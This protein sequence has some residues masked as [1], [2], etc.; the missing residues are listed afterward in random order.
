ME[1]KGLVYHG[2]NKFFTKFDFSNTPRVNNDYYGGPVY[3]TDTVPIAQTYAQAM[4]RRYGGNK[5]IYHV[6]LDLNNVFDVDDKFSGDEL[7]KF[8]GKN[9]EQFARGARLLNY[10][11]DKY[12]V[13]AKLESGSEI[14]TGDQVFRGLSGGMINS[15]RAREKLK[16]L[17]YDGL[18]SNGGANMGGGRHN[19]YL[20]YYPKDIKI[21]EILPIVV[22]K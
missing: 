17:G 22:K 7:K 14:L 6:L 11:V 3:F 8:V 2:S 13:L 16:R 18:R 19:V 1:F 10:G 5:I 4:V 9:S 20:V 15:S 21:K 12:N